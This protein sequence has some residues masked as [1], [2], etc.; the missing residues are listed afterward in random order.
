VAYLSTNHLERQTA[1]AQHFAAW[2]LPGP[3]LSRSD[4]CGSPKSACCI[5][6]R[7]VFAL[8]EPSVLASR[9]LWPT[10]MSSARVKK[11]DVAV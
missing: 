3:V 7:L 8:R 9:A 1:N 5:T 6:R 4:T 11:E 2:Q 10:P